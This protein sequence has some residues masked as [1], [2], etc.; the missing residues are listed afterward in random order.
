M[1]RSRTS[2]GQYSTISS[3]TILIPEEKTPERLAAEGLSIVAAGSA[4]VVPSLP[5]HRLIFS[6]S[7]TVAHT[8]A[9]ISYHL[10]ANQDILKKLQDELAGVMP[11]DDSTPKWSRLEQLPYM[12]GISC[13]LTQRGFLSVLIFR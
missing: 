12:V 13:S 8:L 5:C 2:S 9:V 3:R 7:Q 6:S 10:I 4:F 11:T 1:T